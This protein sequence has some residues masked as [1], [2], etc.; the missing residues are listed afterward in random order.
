M[1]LAEDSLKQNVYPEMLGEHIKRYY[2]SR[3]SVEYV[4]SIERLSDEIGGVMPDILIAQDTMCAHNCVDQ[5]MDIV[6]RRSNR[7]KV[8]LLSENAASGNAEREEARVIGVAEMPFGYEQVIELLDGSREKK[9]ALGRARALAL[10]TEDILFRMSR[11][12]DVVPNGVVKIWNGYAASP[13]QD[14]LLKTIAGRT[15]EGPCKIEFCA[16]PELVDFA[17][18]EASKNEENRS[19]VILPASE[20]IS[21]DSK[22]KLIDAKAHVIFVDP[23]GDILPVLENAPPIAAIAGAGI[24]YLAD[25]DT[26]FQAF[27]EMLTPLET[28][29]EEKI[30]VSVLKKDPGRIVFHLRPLVKFE[31]DQLESINALMLRVITAA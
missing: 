7:T 3:C 18:D 1:I 15:K 31:L 29:G 23:E 24:A 13:T 9:I 28:R 27:Y 14:A 21:G 16:I 6:S 8:I 2:G 26:A 20:K 17:L 10:N 5:I 12:K 11:V 19:V 25:D 4:K 30:T 22:R